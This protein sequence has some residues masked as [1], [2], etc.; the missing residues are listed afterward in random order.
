MPCGNE[1]MMVMLRA[2]LLGANRGIFA[3]KIRAGHIIKDTGRYWRC[4]SNARSQKGQG[5]ASYHMKMV[6]VVSGKSREFASPA[7]KDYPEA[8]TER[9]KLLFSGFDDSDQA[10]FVYPQHSAQAGQEINL[11]GTSLAEYLQKWLACGMP[12]DMLH[13]HGDDE[14]AAATGGAAMSDLYCDIMM[15]SN[16]VYTVEKLGIKG[17]YKLAYFVECDGNVTVSDNVQV[18]DK[19]KVIVRTDGTASF[20]GKA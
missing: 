11:P 2:A 8:R 19:I 10:C 4:I 12:V 15:P 13:I 1:S 6:D 18:G 14:E 20:S 3:D 9:L 7:G 5:A 17:M 16:Y